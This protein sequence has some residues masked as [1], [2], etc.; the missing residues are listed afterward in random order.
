MVTQYQAENE[1]EPAM[2]GTERAGQSIP[3]TEEVS[4]IQLVVQIRKYL[5]LNK[6][7]FLLKLN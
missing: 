4:S 2:D 5:C 3:P 1:S 7:F 6:S